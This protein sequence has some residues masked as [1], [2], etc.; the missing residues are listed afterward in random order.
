M[1]KELCTYIQTETDFIIG[2]DLFAG[3]IPS[4]AQDDC[5]VAIE[6]G[7]K[8]NFYL[9]DK[10]EKVV[11]ILSR[12][13]DYWAAR[14]NAKTIFDLLHGKS[15]IE[16]MYLNTG[17]PVYILSTIEAIALPQSVGQDERGLFN[18][19]VNFIIRLQD[20]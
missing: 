6:G 13:K 18:I 14:N 11:Q 9:P 8:P 16:L 7:G 15:G 19:S 10:E 5:V 1:L 3:F 17:V 2:I 12:A 4:T 20:K